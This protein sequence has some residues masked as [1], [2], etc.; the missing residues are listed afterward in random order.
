[1]NALIIIDEE[2][3][4]RIRAIRVLMLCLFCF[5]FGYLFA[6]M[7]VSRQTSKE[8]VMYAKLQK[9]MAGSYAITTTG[10][11]LRLGSS[12]RKAVVE[13]D[14]VYYNTRMTS[15]G[16]YEKLLWD[17]AQITAEVIDPTHREYF[18]IDQ[19][20]FKGQIATTVGPT[21]WACGE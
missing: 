12:T 5:G 17:V 14:H 15:G 4:S 20:F 8:Y 11:I 21:K 9:A 10:E 7:Q 16:Y 13:G 2:Q 1:M 3:A 19:C 6:Q 18:G